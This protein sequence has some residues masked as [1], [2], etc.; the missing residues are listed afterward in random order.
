MGVECVVI[1]DSLLF[2]E[3][4]HQSPGKIV[5][6][7]Q[8]RRIGDRGRTGVYKQVSTLGRGADP[9]RR[10]HARQF[11]LSAKTEL[12]CHVEPPIRWTSRRQRHSGERLVG[13]YGH[14]GGADYG[15]GNAGDHTGFTKCPDGVAKV[16][17]GQ[18]RLG[19]SR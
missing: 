17:A 4:D 9:C 13:D 6:E 11:H 5:T 2:G 15:L 8:E 14:V 1:V 10:L 3:L 12:G 19:P 18:A 16:A 7:I